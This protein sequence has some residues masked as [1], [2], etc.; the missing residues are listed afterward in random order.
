MSVPC[1]PHSGSFHTHAVPCLHLRLT[2]RRLLIKLSTASD[3]PSHA[4]RLGQVLVRSTTPAEERSPAQKHAYI[5]KAATTLP[6]AILRNP[7][8]STRTFCQTR[9]RDMSGWKT[10]L[11]S[12][13]QSRPGSQITL[14]VLLTQCTGE[15]G[16]TIL[17]LFA[18][19]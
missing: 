10:R 5:R 1:S 13:R 15:D 3:G 14:P 4:S 17:G 12:A 16:Q 18:H 19:L 6:Q 8:S 7:V 2:P 11:V 9:W